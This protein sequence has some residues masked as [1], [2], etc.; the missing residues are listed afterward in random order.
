MGPVGISY[1]S[2]SP[3]H[4][5][6]NFP[7]FLLSCLRG[8]EELWQ[9]SSLAGVGSWS[10]LFTWLAADYQFVIAGVCSFLTFVEQILPSRLSPSF[11]EL[12][13]RKT[14][15]GV[16]LPGLLPVELTER[17]WAGMRCEIQHKPPWHPI[18]LGLPRCLENKK[19]CVFLNFFFK[20]SCLVL[21]AHH[22]GCVSRAS[23]PLR[24]G[25][26]W[27]HSGFCSGGGVGALW[28]TSSKPSKSPSSAILGAP[29]RP[30]LGSHLPLWNA[31]NALPCAG[32]TR[33]PSGLSQGPM[34]GPI[35]KRAAPP[36]G[37]RVSF[38][39][40]CDWATKMALILGDSS[41]LYR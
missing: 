1:V 31:L 22:C 12:P 34:S 32:P 27:S 9:P 40:S 41:F 2:V 39:G 14:L 26:M 38:I 23:V 6:R 19:G 7:S 4:L 5:L 13:A 36:G 28:S 20:G 33:C 3:F 16:F 17:E 24:P 35:S 29:S 10:G 37:C 25:H 15:P 18:A 21:Q 30:R 8:L 11:R